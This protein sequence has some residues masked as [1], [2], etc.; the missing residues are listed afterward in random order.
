ML[1]SKLP[2]LPL[3]Q[4]HKK[5]RAA[6]IVAF[7]SENLGAEFQLELPDGSLK[8][9]KV[10]ASWLT[11]NPKVE[12]GGYFVQYKDGYTAYSPAEPFEAGY[13]LCP[14]SPPVTA[15]GYS[16]KMDFGEAI[17]ALKAGHK[18]ARIGWN[19]KGMYITLIHPGNAMHHGYSMQRCI[20]MKTADYVMQP[21]WLASQADML[22]ED[23]IIVE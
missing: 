14:S 16:Q 22:A 6:K 8:S 4:C 13:A 3:Y 15:A 12:T 19:G 10:Y 23:W 20:G 9:V 2:E 7:W 21:G 5:V 1:N 18:V 17:E 11:R